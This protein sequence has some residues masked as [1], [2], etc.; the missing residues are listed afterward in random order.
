MTTHRKSKR[1]KSSSHL[2]LKHDRIGKMNKKAPH[3]AQTFTKL[4]PKSKD[5]KRTDVSFAFASEIQIMKN[6]GIAMKKS[7]QQIFEAFPMYL[8][9]KTDA[10]RS[11]KPKGKLKKSLQE[12]T[13]FKNETLFK[14]LD[15]IEAYIGDSLI[16]NMSFL[17]SLKSGH[18][19]LKNIC[20]K[21]IG[22]VNQRA[23]KSKHTPPIATDNQ[24]SI[25]TRGRSPGARGTVTDDTTR[26]TLATRST[27]TETTDLKG[28][29][30]QKAKGSRKRKR[31]ISDDTSYKK[32]K[33]SDKQES[34]KRNLKSLRPRVNKSASAGELNC[35]TEMMNQKISRCKSSSES[36]RTE[37]SSPL[38]CEKNIPEKAAPEEHGSFVVPEPLGRTRADTK[39]LTTVCT[40]SDASG[41]IVSEKKKGREQ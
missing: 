41:N 2:K 7:L 23:L 33:V 35:Q 6:H 1:L 12:E 17:N 14:D 34:M 21:W 8:P 28:S 29:E 18:S 37:Q 36:I 38:R 27:C 19:K 5:H 13:S 9:A 10:R 32:Y 20:D 26:G 15:K 25:K 30:E 39:M 22:T 4:R 11:E 31:K 40:G 3:H 16:E 24:C